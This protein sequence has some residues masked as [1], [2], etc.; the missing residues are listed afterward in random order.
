MRES[1]QKSGISIIL[2]LRLA[3]VLLCILSLGS[4]ASVYYY[5]S[6]MRSDGHVVNYAGIVRGT[7]QRVIKLELAGRDNEALINRVDQIIAGLIHGDAQLA[8]PAATD[9]AFLHAMSDV[10]NSW[11]DLRRTLSRA[12]SGEN[13]LL[14]EESETFYELADTAVSIADD[15]ATNHVVSLQTLQ[16]VFLV[17]I[18]LA[19]L[20]A[21]IVLRRTSHILRH[22][23]DSI[24][25]STSTI[26][27]SL[28]EQDG[29]SEQQ[30]AA[31]TETTTTMEELNASFEH[32]TTQADQA[33]SQAQLSSQRADEGNRTAEQTLSEME[34]LKGKVAAIA[35][36]ILQLSE[37]TS[38][39]GQVTELV[40]E[41][42]NQT[43]LLALNASVQAAH[44]GE[45]GR[46][47]AVVAGEIRK[48]ADQSKRSAER[49]SDLVGD[50]QSATNSTVMA[51]EEGTK[52]VDLGMRLTQEAAS[53]FS[54]VATA[55]QD[56]QQS[57]RQV[58]FNIKEQVA[59]VRQVV[60]AM[61]SLNNGAR[62]VSTAIAQTREDIERLD[63]T[64]RDLSAVV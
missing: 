5:M 44:A 42:A 15:S 46:G 23:I 16:L 56:T 51:T 36:Q 1:Q 19:L 3:L 53:A 18:L 12:H 7:P 26:S 14:I 63:Q 21:W 55:L 34:N 25:G 29:M 24:T 54:E 58:S 43:N 45:H 30:A 28:E 57:A 27:V 49:I 37:Q 31:V 4:V 38:Q 2:Q 52:T 10:Q 32:T 41:L 35:A 48:L 64:A 62:E 59:A 60:D 13:T 9:E 61:E 50:I 40:S 11:Y 39:I 6:Q 33:A 8:L 47:F 20:A 22:S 17:I